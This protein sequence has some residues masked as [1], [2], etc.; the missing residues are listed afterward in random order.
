MSIRS[1]VGFGMLGALATCAAVAAQMP[2]AMVHVAPAEKAQVNQSQA[3]V[4]SVEPVTRS[5][6][7]AEEA[8]LIAERT[9]DEGDKVEKGALLSRTKTDLLEK[10][11]QA[12]EAIRESAASM[13]ARAQADAENA[14]RELKRIEALSKTTAMTVKEL[15]DARTADRVSVAMVQVRTA[16][17]AEK[18]AEVARLKLL[19]EK[20]QSRSPISGVVARR[21]VEVGQWI[22]QGDPVAEIVQLDPLFIRVH[23]PE[24]IIASVKKGDEAD[25][26]FDAARDKPVV[27]KVEQILPEGDPNSRT[28]VVKLLLPNPNLE[29]RPGFFARVTR[30]DRA[31]AGVVVLRDAIVAKGENAHVVVMREGKAVMVPVKRGPADGLKQL[32]FGEIKQGEMVVTRGNE[33]LMPGQTLIPVNLAPPGGGGQ[34]GAQ[35]GSG[36]PA[37]KPAGPK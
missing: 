9:F 34:G 25:V 18:E 15:N 16:D 20:A 32:V 6:L 22:K 3:L 31:A 26:I 7:A 29:Y 24:D 35:P 33:S 30:R 13:L 21:H 10:Q 23:V 4:A 5:V 2:P 27:A 19:I 17:M 8:G 37:T 12:A 28:F 1:W 36:G 14:V 11:L